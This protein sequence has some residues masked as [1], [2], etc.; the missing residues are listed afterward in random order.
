MP[1][2]E[3]IIRRM[4]L[5]SYPYWKKRP[6]KEVG[7]TK[8]FEV[9][10]HSSKSSSGEISSS[11][12]PDTF[13][14]KPARSPDT[15]N[16]RDDSADHE[17]NLRGRDRYRSDSRDNSADYESNLRGRDCHPPESKGRRQ[18]RDSTSKS[19]ANYNAGSNSS[20]VAN[21]IEVNGDNFEDL[22]SWYLPLENELFLNSIISAGN[23][24]HAAIPAYFDFLEDSLPPRVTPES[25]N[26]AVPRLCLI[27]LLSTTV[28][29]QPLTLNFPS[30]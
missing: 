16:P 30:I 24:N 7:F 25:Q 29:S 21:H 17:S 20:T 28:I 13:C 8:T 15:Q 23:V 10:T 19:G 27:M 14:R 5:L 4:G 11:S 3:D 9:S 1:S 18:S 26:L 6:K 12:N 22:R 2:S